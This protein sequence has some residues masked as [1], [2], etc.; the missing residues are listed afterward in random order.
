ML[1]MLYGCDGPAPQSDNSQAAAIQ[2]EARP[3][4]AAPSAT[5]AGRSRATAPAPATTVSPAAAPAPEGPGKNTI[6]NA[7]AEGDPQPKPPAGDAVSANAPV[8]PVVDNEVSSFAKA[9]AKSTTDGEMPASGAAID[10]SA[11]VQRSMAGINAP[12]A[13]RARVEE[14][15][16]ADPGTV[17]GDMF[18]LNTPGQSKGSLG[19]VHVHR[20]NGQLRALFRVVHTG[21][22]FNYFD[23][24]L[25]RRADGRYAIDD[26]YS[27]IDDSFDSDLFKT[28]LRPLLGGAMPSGSGLAGGAAEIDTARYEMATSNSAKKYQEALSIYAALPG[29]LKK[30]KFLFIERIKAARQ[31][32]GVPYD[33]AIRDYRRESPQA[34]NLKMFMI[35]GYVQHKLYDRALACIDSLDQYVGGDPYLNVE[36]A[37]VHH[38]NGDLATAKALVNKA[39]EAEPYLLPAYMFLLEISLEE[40]NYSETARLLTIVR[41]KFPMHQPFYATDPPYAG[42]MKSRA[43][44]TWSSGRQ[45]W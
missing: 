42:F 43:Y 15:A 4:S 44:Q 41:E 14:R 8:E 22:D 17:A 27:Y 1:A 40:K 33:E 16:A 2:S 21:Q 31:V 32:K 35:D 3:I 6:G 29:T 25:A 18:G 23:G 19:F 7:A 45:P 34:T 38:L 39:V 36:R 5:A 30:D 13:L 12:E 28:L 11:Y 24:I 10:T 20:V 26:A 37:K 9:F